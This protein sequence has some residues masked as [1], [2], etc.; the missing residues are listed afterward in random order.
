MFIRLLAARIFRSSNA[1]FSILNSHIVLEVRIFF[2]KGKKSVAFS[3]PESVAIVL[4][5]PDAVFASLMKHSSVPL[6][7]QF[8]R[9]A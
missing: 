4:D 7:Q 3:V 8:Y 6:F 1:R 9:K 5:G 2:L